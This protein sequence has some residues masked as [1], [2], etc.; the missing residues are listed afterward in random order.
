[1]KPIVIGFAGRA[2]VGKTTIAN[3]LATNLRQRGHSV[4]VA[5]FAAPVKRIA[6]EMGWDGAKDAKGRRLLQLL[7]TECGRECIG[8]DVWVDL[9]RRENI[10]RV[11][12]P[13]D[14][15]IID[16]V[17]FLN[18]AAMIRELDGPVY[19]VRRRSRLPWWRRV[20]SRLRRHASER[21]PIK[22][23]GVILNYGTK[24]DL[25]S[26]ADRIAG[27]VAA[28]VRKERGE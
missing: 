5:P 28:R 4:S 12:I 1:M 10:D 14:V 25:E 2:E 16:D 11:P 9:W 20:W 21:V 8:P 22:P 17:R 26:I 24:G 19:E 7:G 18:E 15:L 13:F 6:R 27:E 3:A 23:D